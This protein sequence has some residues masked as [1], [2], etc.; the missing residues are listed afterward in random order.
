M[1]KVIVIFFSL[2]LLTG[3]SVDKISK[4]D[5]N[6]I[7][8][9]TLKEEIK[10]Y[11]NVFE[12]YKLYVPRGLKVIDKNDYNLKIL[13]DDDTFYLYVDVVAYHYK[14]KKSF[15]PS[16]DN[17]LSKE[18][19]Y[20][21]KFGYINITEVN[22]KYFIEYMYNYSKIESYIEK[23]NLNS[24]ILNMTYILSSINY[25]DKTINMLMDNN[26]LDYKEEKYDI[27][28]SKKENSNFLEALEKYD[29]YVEKEPDDQDVLNFEELE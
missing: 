29:N 2:L 14:T 26:I 11:N 25:N 28:E 8:D 1:K 19:K 22:D 10:L 3:C 23:K 4:L 13:S 27:F 5:V 20:K 16:N 9:T 6:K 7:I 21:D 18:I 17:F 24:T 15:E 12:G